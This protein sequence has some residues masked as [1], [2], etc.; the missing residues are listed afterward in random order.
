MEVVLA[1]SIRNVFTSEQKK[2]IEGESV[3]GEVHFV[4]HKRERR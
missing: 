4:G 2:N 1:V 3:P